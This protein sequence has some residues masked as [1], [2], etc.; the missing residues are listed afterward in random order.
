MPLI[1][2]LSPG[3]AVLVRKSEHSMSV[4]IVKEGLGIG[5]RRCGFEFWLWYLTVSWGK[6]CDLS[7]SHGSLY[8]KRARKRR[9]R[10][11]L[12]I[13]Y[14]P[15]KWQ[16][17]SCF[18]SLIDQNNIFSPVGQKRRKLCYN[19]FSA[20]EYTDNGKINRGALIFLACKPKNSFQCQKLCLS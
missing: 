16:M 7:V 20:A 11:C 19:P 10:R 12:L 17:F 13:C 8:V 4:I 2:F 5:I 1:V 15:L 14:T 9:Y 18:S 3:S 6:S